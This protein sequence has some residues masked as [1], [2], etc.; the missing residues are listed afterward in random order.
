LVQGNNTT[1]K[2]FNQAYCINPLEHPKIKKILNYWLQI[3][4]LLAH[5]LPIIEIKPYASWFLPAFILF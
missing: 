1:D 3:A 4:N 5:V 2:V